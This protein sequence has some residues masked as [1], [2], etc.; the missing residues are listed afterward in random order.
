MAG[1]WNYNGNGNNQ[2]TQAQ[3]NAWQDPNRLTPEQIAQMRRNNEAD[4]RNDNDVN[5]SAL[6]NANPNAWW[7]GG[8]GPD[9]YN[10]EKAMLE[11][12][13]QE[14][15]NR[16]GPQVDQ[17]GYNADRTRDTLA[18]QQQNAGLGMLYRTAMGQS[19]PSVAQMQAGNQVAQAAANMRAQAAS[20]RGGGGNAAAAMRT[21]IRQGGAAG[22]AAANQ[23]GILRA[24]EQLAAQQAYMQGASQVRGAEQAR[25][26]QSANWA[27]GNTGAQ[28][29][30]QRQN[31]QMANAQDAFRA[32]AMQ[33]NTQGRQGEQNWRQNAFSDINR[34]ELGQQAQSDANTGKAIG[35][36]GSAVA[37]LLPFIFSDERLKTGVG[38]GAGE[39]R[40]ALDNL[41]PKSFEYKDGANGEGERLGIMAQDLEKSKYG[42]SIVQKNGD[43][44]RM[45]DGGGGLNMALAAIA[46]L[47]QRVKKFE[48][49]K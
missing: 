10:A 28:Q 33:Q 11:R 45:V 9:V 34:T 25:M 1:Q 40:S 5:D 36:A 47:H 2:M 48:G 42:K 46:D 3:Q 17:T 8:E 15:A 43:G 19:G 41:S 44:M 24:Q 26:G 29:A 7:Y 20:A 32:N 38:N 13:R 27:F 31:D 22:V 23:G 49:K 16:V 6:R 18:S 30:N 21:A 39:I 12:R 37:A 14:Y 35:T 4:F